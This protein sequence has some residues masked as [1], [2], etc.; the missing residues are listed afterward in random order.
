MTATQAAFFSTFCPGDRLRSGRGYRAGWR[1]VRRAGRWCSAVPRVPT[2]GLLQ[3]C[4][5]RAAEDPHCH[6][7][8][9][10]H[11]DSREARPAPPLCT[12]GPGPLALGPVTPLAQEAQGKSRAALPKLSKSCT[13]LPYILLF[14]PRTLKGLRNVQIA[15]LKSKTLQLLTSSS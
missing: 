2:P 1:G 12:G 8:P 13:A 11:K 5:P 3:G 10:E 14:V 4:R 7:V 15:L 9:P 6:L